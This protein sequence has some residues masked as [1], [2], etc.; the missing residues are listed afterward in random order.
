MK[1]LVVGLGVIGATYGYLFEKA[2]HQV[3]HYIRDSSSRTKLAALDVDL[4]DGRKRKTSSHVQDLYH[5]QKQSQ[6]AYDFIFVSLPEGKIREAIDYLQENQISGT[7]LLACGIWQDR[8]SL[9]ELMKGRDYILGYPVAGGRISDKQLTACV[10][11]HFMLEEKNKAGISNYTDLE[12]LFSSCQIQ[13]EKPYDMLEWI[14]LHMAI[15]AGVISTIAAHADLKNP[16]QAAEN[17][18]NSTR[19]LSQAVRAVRETIKMVKSRGVILSH[20]HQDCLPYRLPIWL[21]A[22]LMKRMFA[23]NIL[24][25]KIM[26]LHNNL[27][28]LFF[29]CQCLY[30]SGKRNTVLA[31]IFYQAY[32]EALQ[33]TAVNKIEL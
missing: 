14:W 5:V 28:D 22:P 11:D 24:S 4:L 6:K 29:V 15:N 17:L 3:E 25:R 8:H 10:F 2:G 12:K 16:S 19:L 21:S 13:L 23:K 26:T 32:E 27:P 1:V 31:P 33:K 30:D 9:D 18:M 20:Y 7:I